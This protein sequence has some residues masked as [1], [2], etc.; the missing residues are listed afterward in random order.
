MRRTRTRRKKRRLCVYTQLNDGGGGL[1]FRLLDH[2]SSIKIYRAGMVQ[3]W[4]VE[5]AEGSL[6]LETHFVSTLKI[7]KATKSSSSSSLLSSSSRSLGVGIGSV[8]RA[9]VST[10][11]DGINQSS[12]RRG[13]FS[14]SIFVCLFVG[15]YF[16]WFV[17]F[18][19]ISI[20]VFFSF[21]FLSIFLYIY[22]SLFSIEGIC[23]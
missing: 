19:F 17:H 14:F 3:L 23:V 21:D 16:V 20:G 22:L 10:Q 9:A 7:I 6:S 1:T 18:R 4:T 12:S 8:S 15:F 5:W 11:R 13:S 2:Q